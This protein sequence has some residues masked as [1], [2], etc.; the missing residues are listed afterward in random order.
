MAAE[1]K[2]WIDDLERGV[3]ASPPR[4][5]RGWIGPFVLVAIAAALGIFSE[6]WLGVIDP[7]EWA[8]DFNIYHDALLSAGKS[9]SPYLPYVIGSS[10][11]YHPFALTLVGPIAKLGRFPA[12]I[13]WALVNLAGYAGAL[14][15]SLALVGGV[16]RQ[17]T[18]WILALFAVFAPMWEMFHIG[19]INGI[20]LACVIGSL[21]LSE[22]ERPILAGASLALAIVLK[23][24][25]LVFVLWFAALRQWRLVVAALSFLALLSLIAWGQFGTLVMRDYFV[26]VSRLGAETFPDFYN[27]SFSAVA[28]RGLWVL[29]VR[30]IEPHVALTQRGSAMFLLVLVLVLSA[31]APPADR[32]LRLWWFALVSAITTLA[33]PLVWYHHN[34]FLVLPLLVLFAAGE[35]SWPLV[36]GVVAYFLIQA[37]R[38]IEQYAPPVPYD[39]AGPSIRF[40]GQQAFAGLPVL[41]AHALLL[42]AMAWLVVTAYRRGA[43]GSGSAAAAGHMKRGEGMRRRPRNWC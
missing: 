36:A 15:M 24:S 43:R 13:V 17:R 42:A 20:V 12:S 3:A 29:G 31:A 9:R 38:L 16:S 25:P 23:S 6:V 27:Q 39:Y 28:L 5:G 35:S 14:W 8:S 18:A 34:V 7:H 26:V 41:I 40:M 22:S 10:F 37:E 11:L 19:Q 2:R 4:L 33:S 32:R 1:K 30:G 21:Y